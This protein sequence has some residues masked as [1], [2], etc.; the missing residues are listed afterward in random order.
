MT[1][2]HATAILEHE[3]AS[4]SM[5]TWPGMADWKNG[6]ILVSLSAPEFIDE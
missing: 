6:T 1:P 4:L 3:V 5:M 2:S